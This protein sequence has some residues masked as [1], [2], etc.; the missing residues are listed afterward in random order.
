M[1][2]ML[3]YERE[4]SAIELKVRFTSHSMFNK[5]A[6][7][8]TS[9]S[10]FNEFLEFL[11]ILLMKVSILSHISLHIRTMHLHTLSILVSG[12]YLARCY[13]DVSESSMTFEYYL[14]LRG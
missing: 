7:S 1:T 5:H 13:V 6:T 14:F 3:N 9:I 8:D 4:G 10:I 11:S 12:T 2:K